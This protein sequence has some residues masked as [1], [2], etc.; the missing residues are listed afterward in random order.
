VV[1]VAKPQRLELDSKAVDV[2]RAHACGSGVTFKASYGSPPVRERHSG[3]DVH[4]GGRMNSRK[5]TR[6]A[7]RRWWSGLD[8]DVA[9]SRCRGGSTRCHAGP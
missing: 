3:A 9:R 6:W 5:V 7:H 4:Y 8:G 1:I 2:K